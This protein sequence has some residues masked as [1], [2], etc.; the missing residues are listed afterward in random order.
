MRLRIVLAACI[1]A[2]VS[3]PF[4]PAE[5]SAATATNVASFGGASD[6]GAGGAGGAVVDLASTP[7]GEGYWLA[8]ADGS[9][10][11]VGVTSYGSMAGTVL[12]APIIAISATPSGHGYWLL[13]RD[14]GIFSFGDAAFRGS[15]GAVRLNDPV[16]DLAP[17]PTGHGYWLLGRDGGI[18]SFGD[19]RFFG[20]AADAIET[21][22]AIVVSPSGAGYWLVAE[23]G[24]VRHFGDADDVGTLAGTR[25]N[26]PVTAAAVAPS[27]GLWLLG[28]DGGVFSM[29]AAPFFGGASVAAGYE[30]VALV[31]AGTD[32]PG[33]WIA[34]SVAT[35]QSSLPALPGG[36]GTGRR[37]VYSNGMQQVWVVDTG[38]VLVRTYLV[39]GRVG[40]PR[41][42]TYQIFSKL[43]LAYAYGGGAYMRHFMGFAGGV[44]FHE[45]P[46]L[47]SNGQPMQTEAELGQFRSHGCVRQAAVDASW[48]YDWASVGD[49]VVVLP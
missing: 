15:M 45:I 4:A 6:L 22:T 11:G 36:S 41:P 8:S 47:T 25:L 9:V 28:A 5:A 32:G 26:A 24:D 44:G 13:G 19:A 37:I 23:N 46:R 31:V 43:N 49:T 1:A 10:T 27:G 12:N 21:F 16:I 34:V 30:A 18:F 35:F 17:T 3:L 7:D 42:G 20:S 39:S 33:Y 29:G 2:A 40:T 48:L 14:G 38:E